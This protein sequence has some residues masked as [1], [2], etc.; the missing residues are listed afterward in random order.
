MRRKPPGTMF[1]AI[2][3][4]AYL[5]PISPSSITI[6][7][8]TVRLNPFAGYFHLCILFDMNTHSH[9]CCTCERHPTLPSGPMRQEIATRVMHS[10]LPGSFSFPRQAILETQSTLVALLT[11]CYCRSSNVAMPAKQERHFSRHY[12]VKAS[13][14]NLFRSASSKHSSCKAA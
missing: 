5:L 9:S 14:P 13:Q 7:H 4:I 12:L 10:R 11:A 2:L 3:I 8:A 6:A 1:S